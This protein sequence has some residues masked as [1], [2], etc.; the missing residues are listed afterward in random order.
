MA[1]ARQQAKIIQMIWQHQSPY[2]RLVEGW[3]ESR[4]T[5][6]TGAV[7]R[8]EFCHPVCRHGGGQEVHL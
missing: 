1:L 7:A 2:Q 4:I 8:I 5:V 3:N 6:F